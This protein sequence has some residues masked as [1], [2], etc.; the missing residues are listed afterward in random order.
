MEPADAQHGLQPKHANVKLLMEPAD[1]QHGLHNPTM[2]YVLLPMEP[3]ASHNCGIHW[4][5]L[6]QCSNP[7]LSR[8]A[9]I[10]RG[11]RSGRTAL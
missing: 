8:D 11:L 3:A 9:L 6:H 5:E 7:R 1:T 4:G 2:P 10:A